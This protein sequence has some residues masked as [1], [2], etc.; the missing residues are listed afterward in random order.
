[1]LLSSLRG[2]A[3]ELLR[4]PSS[5]LSSY[6]LTSQIHLRDNQ[7]WTTQLSQRAPASHV[8]F[9]RSVKPGQYFVTSSSIST[10]FTLSS[11]M[12]NQSFSIFIQNRIKITRIIFVHYIYVYM[13]KHAFTT[14]CHCLNIHVFLFTTHCR[15]WCFVPFS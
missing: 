7:S 13:I 2:W 1:M 9:S 6:T 10:L 5:I 15:H 12:S 11:E 4:V 8:T 3:K 14:V